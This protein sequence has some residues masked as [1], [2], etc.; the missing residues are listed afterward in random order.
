M[1]ERDRQ[2]AY[3]QEHSRLR[4]AALKE[5]YSALDVT[6]FRK[7]GRC[8]VGFVLMVSGQCFAEPTAVSGNNW[9]EVFDKAHNEIPLAGHRLWAKITRYDEP[10]YVETSEDDDRADYEYERARDCRMDSND[11]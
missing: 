7:N 10:A 9:T 5:G 11:A 8:H 4:E 3:E 6:S 2:F 1:T